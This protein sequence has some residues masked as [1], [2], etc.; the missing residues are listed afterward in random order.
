MTTMRSRATDAP[1]VCAIRLAPV[2]GDRVRRAEPGG[3]SGADCDACERVVRVEFDRL[4]AEPGD[5]VL[6][7]A[8]VDGRCGESKQPADS[9]PGEPEIALIHG[10]DLPP[11]GEASRV[12]V[13]ISMLEGRALARAAGVLP[14][15]E[16]PRLREDGSSCGGCPVVDVRVDESRRLAP[17]GSS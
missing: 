10:V 16:L 2:R 5:I 14:V 3:C 1:A 17:G 8:C 9:V 6:V 7:R 15:A 12:R 4:D 13:S 11:T